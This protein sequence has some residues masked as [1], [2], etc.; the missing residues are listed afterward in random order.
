MSALAVSRQ[1]QLDAAVDGFEPS[2]RRLTTDARPISTPP[3]VV[4]ASMWPD[5]PSPLMPPFTELAVTSFAI[6]FSRTP[7]LVVRA[8]T[9]ID[10]GTLMK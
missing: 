4:F 6:P 3:F 2:R 10:F 5:S 1:L 8:S 7:P 9:L